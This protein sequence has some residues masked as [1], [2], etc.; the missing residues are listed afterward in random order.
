MSKYCNILKF[1]KYKSY[2]NFIK[3]LPSTIQLFVITSLHCIKY[4]TGNVAF[5]KKIIIYKN[6]LT[7]SQQNKVENVKKGKICFN[8]GINYC[9]VD[10]SCFPIDKIQIN[11]K[12][13]AFG[14]VGR[15]FEAK[16][17]DENVVVKIIPLNVK[18][19]G[20]G[21]YKEDC[22]KPSSKNCLDVTVEEFK[23]EV[24][25]FK[26]ASKH[27]IAPKFYGSSICKV[28]GDYKNIPKGFRV[29]EVGIIVSSKI[30]ITLEDYEGEKGPIMPLLTKLKENM[31]KYKFYDNDIHPG[32]IGI[33][34]KQGK[35][36]KAYDIDVGEAEIISKNVKNLVV[37]TFTNL[38]SHLRED[39]Y[40]N[41]MK[42]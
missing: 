1:C 6:K 34:Y 5:A 15:V 10:T 9:L 39:K 16:M 42:I 32:N 12:M 22:P 35:P 31:I 17:G 7:Q 30:D 21:Q 26:Y 40:W 28:E 20:M 11:K 2:L 13:L 4:K 8:T 33:L 18:I 36:Y 27:N 29:K 25:M 23:D 24:K 37:R 14:G 19:K 41:Y 3:L 38:K